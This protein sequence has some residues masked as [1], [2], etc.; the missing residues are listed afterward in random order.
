MK[1]VDHGWLEGLPLAKLHYAI[2]PLLVGSLTYAHRLGGAISAR[3]FSYYA[4]KR[5]HAAAT[6]ARIAE[7]VLAADQRAQPEEIEHVLAGDLLPRRR[8]RPG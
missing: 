7:F 8:S 4:L 5:L 3:R 1:V 2:T 6:R